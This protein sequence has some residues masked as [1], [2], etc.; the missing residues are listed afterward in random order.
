MTSLDRQATK[1]QEKKSEAAKLRRKS[2]REFKKASSLAKRTVSGLVSLERKIETSREQLE[3]VSG[4]LTQRLA[5]QESIQRLKS[6]AEERLKREKEAKDQVEQEIEFA[7][8]EEEKQQALSR[9]RSISDR[10]DELV[11]EIKQ[12]NK[13]AQKITQALDDYKKSK[14]RISTKIQKQTHSKPTLQKLIKTSKKARERFAKQ[15]VSKTRLEESTKKNIAQINK[16]LAELAAKRR[17]QAAKRATKKR[18]KKS[19]TRTKKKKSK[20]K[21]AKKSKIKRKSTKTKT[22]HK[23]KAKSRKRK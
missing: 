9:L 6:A 14:S 16:K 8:S 1:L 5:Q 17:K 15:V 18:T 7:D 12:R 13:M 2:E 23:R 22:K 11:A 20:I 4:V 10:I 19:K 3:D 21:R